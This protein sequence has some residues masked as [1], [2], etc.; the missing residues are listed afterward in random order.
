M[1]DPIMG[2][3]GNPLKAQFVSDA[4]NKIILTLAVTASKDVEVRR[5]YQIGVIGYGEYVGPALGGALSGQPLAWI[6]DV[7]NNPLRVEDRVKKQSDGAGGVIEV[8]AKF[9]V[10]FE[11]VANGSTPMTQALEQG[12]AILQ[13]WVQSHGLAYPP[14]VINLTDGE[15]DPGLD[16]AVVSEQ[17]KELCTS[18]GNVV[19]LTVHVSSNPYAKEIFFPNTPEAL[20]DAYSRKMYAMSSHLTPRMMETSSQLLQ[21]SLGVGAK[22]IVYQSGIEGIVQ[23]LEIG[24]RPANLR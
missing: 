9:P 5:Y 8:S 19:L 22:G 2:V 7:Y 20:P 6:D 10:W 14:T 12:R 11:P 13:D 16:P 21:I 1:A 24:T 3:A 4:L 23:A 17:I 18:D 15:P